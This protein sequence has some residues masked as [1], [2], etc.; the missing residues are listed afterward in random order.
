MTQK[1]IEDIRI[2]EMITRYVIELI[3]REQKMTLADATKLWYNSKTKAILLD[4]EDDYTHLAPAVCYDELMY[5]V[6]KDPYWMKRD[7]YS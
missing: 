2:K 4:G 1:E 7:F 6:N 3:I 5:E